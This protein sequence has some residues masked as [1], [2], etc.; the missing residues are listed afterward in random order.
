VGNGYR[1]E[2]I[3][4]RQKDFEYRIKDVFYKSN[5]YTIKDLKINGSMLIQE[6]NL[7]SGKQ[8]GKI[9][10]YLLNIII[11]D[12]TKNTKEELIKIVN[13]ILKKY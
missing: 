1:K 11:E 9:L 3:T 12:P 7:T 4:N 2:L 8:I 13:D 6:F 5:G 10:D